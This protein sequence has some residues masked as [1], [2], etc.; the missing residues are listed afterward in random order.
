MQGEKKQEALFVPPTKESAD[1]TKEGFRLISR[2]PAVMAENVNKHRMCASCKKK[3]KK[4]TTSALLHKTK[5][6]L[7]YSFFLFFK[8]FFLLLTFL[9]GTNLFNHNI[10]IL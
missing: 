3:K 4:E 6:F 7:E 9:F 2:R 1:S 5:S 8:S 10:L